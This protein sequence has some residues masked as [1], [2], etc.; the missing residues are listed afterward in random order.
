MKTS[1]AAAASAALSVLLASGCTSSMPKSEN[2]SSSEVAGPASAPSEAPRLERRA[3]HGAVLAGQIGAL[4]YS[5]YRT[6]QHPDRG[7]GE[8][9]PSA[10]Q[11]AEDLELLGEIG[12][13]L[14]RLYDSDLLSQ[15]VLGVIRTRRLAVK[16]VLGAW[17]SAEE[18][19]HE[20]CAW[21]ETEV[22]AE[23]LARNRAKNEAQVAQLVAL[24]KEYPDIIAAVNIGNEALV[25]W[26]D[27]LVPI[28]RMVGYLR[29]VGAAI[30]QPVTTAD[31]YLAWVEHAEA[32]G[33]VVDFAMLHSY[34][35]WEGKTLDEALS[36]TAQNVA[37]VEAA[38]PST[39]L[40]FGEVGWPTTARE[41][42]EQ[43]GTSE[44]ARYVRELLGWAREHGMSTFLFEAFDEDWKGD[45]NPDGA[46]KHWGLFTVDRKPKEAARILGD[47]GNA[48]L[49]SP[50]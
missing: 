49:R 26:N 3:G 11:I 40:A 10:E 15:R 1:K 13:R 38:L 44:Q 5:G 28:E 50:L 41:F 21:V 37:L 31:N 32:L 16:V 25:R 29:Q 8:I 22:P 14:I 6:G 17:L 23:E 4:A 7:E 34:P 46:E 2:S 30:E 9:A 12:G 19:S 20:T 24:A 45:A 18:S 33:P 35:I 47:L 42:P 39:P 43:A 27:H 36:F 48:V